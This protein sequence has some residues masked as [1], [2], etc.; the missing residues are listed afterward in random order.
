[1]CLIVNLW[2]GK[3][4]SILIPA[5]FK[6]FMI[7]VFLF[8]YFFRPSTSHRSRPSQLDSW[9]HPK[10]RYTQ[11]GTGRRG[12]RKRGGRCVEQDNNYE[13]LQIVFLFVFCLFFVVKMTRGELNVAFILSSIF[14]IPAFFDHVFFLNDIENPLTQLINTHTYLRLFFFF[15]ERGWMKS[16][17]FVCVS[18]R[19]WAS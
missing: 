5:H 1:M 19:F 4:L 7:I 9:L 11:E 16:F 14:F 15:Q 6:I 12:G 17:D 8:F 13:P 2:T 3:P 10:E 18:S